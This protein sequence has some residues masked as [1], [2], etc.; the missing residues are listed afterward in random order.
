MD[1]DVLALLKTGAHA[2]VDDL[3]AQHLVPLVHVVL[4]PPVR[5]R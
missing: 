4:V 2:A 3:K 5:H 1:G